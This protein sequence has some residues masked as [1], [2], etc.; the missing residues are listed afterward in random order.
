MAKGF[1]G[2]ELG[3]LTRWVNAKGDPHRQGDC[4]G[5]GDLHRGLADLELLP[6]EA[7][8]FPSGERLSDAAAI[9]GE[10]ND[11]IPIEVLGGKVQADPLCKGGRWPPSPLGGRRSQS[12]KSGR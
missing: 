6:G 8:L 12:P 11:D 9:G 1:D 2:I 7:G 3:G 4:G 5:D 10:W